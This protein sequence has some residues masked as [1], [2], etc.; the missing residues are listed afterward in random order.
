MDM[1]EFL[2][3]RG[4]SVYIGGEGGVRDKHISNT[5]EWA[6]MQC[7]L[8]GTDHLWL[9]Y[10]LK[11]GYF[12]CFNHGHASK[13][14]LFKTWFPT[15]NIKELLD[16]IEN[17]AVVWEEP[18]ILGEYLPPSPLKP[19]LNE[20]DYVR[21]V[22]SRGLDPVVLSKKWGVAVLD[23]ADEWQYRHRLFFPVCNS[24]GKPVSW[25]T[26]TVLPDNNYRY[27]TAPK[28][29]EAMPIKS[30]L[31]G[32]QFVSFFD[33]VIVCEGVFDALRIGRNAVATLGKKITSVQFD[34]IGK[35]QRRIIC[36]DS[37]L[38]T[39]EQAKELAIRLQAFPGRTDNV[40]LDAPDPAEAPASEIAALLKFAELV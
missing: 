27:L 20:R 25:L 17:D 3:S 32:E 19:L 30:L 29:R 39:Q 14:Q 5:G 40:C 4:I 9:G 8:C 11:S 31:Y 23:Y 16:S 21:Y 38:D 34:K 6:Q 1:V 37:E 18:E 36:F 33:T 26:R 13:W 12:N 7:P 28:D 22:K 24:S 35:F 15:E 10:S 2:R